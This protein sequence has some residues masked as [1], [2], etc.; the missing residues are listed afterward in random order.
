[1]AHLWLHDDRGWA[2][3]ALEPGTEVPL[4]RLPVGSRQAAGALL[5]LSG[6]RVERW[7]LLAPLG[8]GVRINGIRLTTGFAVLE[9]RDQVR[10]ASDLAFYYS[11]E[12]LARAEALPALVGPTACARCRTPIL[13][14]TPATRCP[15]CES[16]YHQ[17]SDFGCWTHHETCSVC[18]E[19]TDHRE[20]FR[21]IPEER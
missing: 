2:A 4:A 14:G 10:L 1:M 18:P 6:G 11:T 5:P 8:G 13:H 16:W 17:S 12:R 9:H 19:P 7:A 20:S 3:L 15:G 21:W